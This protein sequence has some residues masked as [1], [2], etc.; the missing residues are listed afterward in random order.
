MYVTTEGLLGILSL[1]FIGIIALNTIFMTIMTWRFV[2][3]SSQVLRDAFNCLVKIEERLTDIAKSLRSI[4]ASFDSEDL[5]S[6]RKVRSSSQYN[7]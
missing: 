2:S 5:A 7:P 6:R 4:E 3:I 1:I